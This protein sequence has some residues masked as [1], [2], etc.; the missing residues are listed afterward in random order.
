MI[1]IRGENI[2][3][4]VCGEIYKPIYCI[5]FYPGPNHLAAIEVYDGATAREV[6]VEEIIKLEK[7]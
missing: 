5:G 3:R 1:M 6:N 2:W 7:K 4:E